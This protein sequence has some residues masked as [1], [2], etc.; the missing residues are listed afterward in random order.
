MGTSD[1]GLK[2]EVEAE[3]DDS[4]DEAPLD[5]KVR[6]T[7]KPAFPGM[8]ELRAEHNMPG[9]QQREELLRIAEMYT[10]GRI[11]PPPVLHQGTTSLKS[12]TPN[13]SLDIPSESACSLCGADTQSPD[14]K[15][16][17]H[18]ENICGRGTIACPLCAKTFTLWNHYEAHKKC[19]QKL[20]QRQYPCQSCGKIFTSASNRNMHQ[21]IHKGVRPFQ[22]APCGVYFRQKAHLQ[23]HQRTQGHIQASELYE[24]RKAE[25]LIQE[26]DT[27]AKKDE[28]DN[29]ETRSE[30][31]LNTADSSTSSNPESEVSKLSDFR[32]SPK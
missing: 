18:G 20:K 24:K 12:E 27:S 16:S 21:R 15:P 13:D 31:S 28:L 5:L 4:E 25:G 30:D 7:S 29:S 26:P 3:Q 8:T 11:N 23:K 1:I 22:C 14:F 32:P 19:H 9:P 10:S 6:P 17:D 2:A